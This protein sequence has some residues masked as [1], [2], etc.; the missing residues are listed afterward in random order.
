MSFALVGAD[1]EHLLDRINDP[2]RYWSKHAGVEELQVWLVPFRAPVDETQ[3]TA[4]RNIGVTAG[5]SAAEFGNGRVPRDGHWHD[6]HATD[7]RD[8]CV[9]ANA[10]D[11]YLDTT[12]FVLDVDYYQGAFNSAEVETSTSYLDRSSCGTCECGKVPTCP[13]HEHVPYGPSLSSVD[14]A[15]R[16]YT[17]VINL[18]AYICESRRE[19]KYLGDIDGAVVLRVLYNDMTAGALA[20]SFAGTYYITVA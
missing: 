6:L 20:K 14:G 10:E 18:G 5:V 11:F 4:A 9:W 15:G 8:L 19:F 16:G 7:R 12:E 1:V 3:R 17:C 2:K 13:Q